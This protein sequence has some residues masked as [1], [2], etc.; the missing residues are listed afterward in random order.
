LA[1]RDGWVHVSIADDG[2]GFVVGDR[3]RRG[4]LL[5][6]HDRVR[7]FG[8]TLSITSTPGQGTQVVAAFPV[9]APVEA[10]QP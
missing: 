3:R 10:A 6:M 1:L 5:H 7:S 8:G 9:R 2:Q 4:G